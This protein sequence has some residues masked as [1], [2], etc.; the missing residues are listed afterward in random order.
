MGGIVG[1]VTTWDFLNRKELEENGARE[2]QNKVKIRWM[3]G[4][5]GF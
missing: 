1:K 3:I 5:L 4:S 2:L